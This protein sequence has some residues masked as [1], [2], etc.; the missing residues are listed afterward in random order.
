M[1]KTT[2]TSRTAAAVAAVVALIGTASACAN[3]SDDR[4]PERRSFALAGGELTIDS[5]DSAIVVKPA[6]V[7]EVRV[8]RWLDGWAVLGHAPEAT[9][10]MRGN[11]LSLRTK[12]Q[13]VVQD[14]AVRHEVLVP[15]GVG[16]TV[17]SG[18]G[19]VE[20]SG[21][22]T[23]LRL[24]TR[25]GSVVVRDV[26][27]PLR[28]SSGD[29]RIDAGGIGS[30]EVRVHTADGSVT[31]AF[32]GVPD[33]VEATSGDGRVRVALP[34]QSYKVS[35]HSGDGHVSVDVPRDAASGHVVTVRTGDGSVSVTEA[36]R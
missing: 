30:R 29:G 4:E 20:A 22:H 26:T 1:T 7:A 32:D 6:D 23:P 18:D 33:L 5:S 34:H 27:G 9:W 28:L 16:L 12:C 35:A 31:L 36:G 11:T 21:F 19:R 8:T 15:R 3:A 14:C 13:G 25:D 24:T 10:A 17:V 2:R